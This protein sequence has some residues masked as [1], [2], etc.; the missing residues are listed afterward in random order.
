MAKRPQK[1]VMERHVTQEVDSVFSYL[2]TLRD[3]GIV[4]RSLW[5]RGIGNASHALIPSLF[6]HKTSVTKA[7]YS[8]L[9]QELNATFKMR[10]FP[11]TE[12]YKWQG[13]SWAQLFFMQHYRVPTRLLDWSGSP[14]IAL[15]FALTSTRLNSLGAPETDAAVWVLD[16][17]AWNVAVYEGTRFDGKVLTPGD[18][19]ARLSRYSPEDVYQSPSNFPPVAMR[20]IHNSAR[21]VAQQGFFTI[22]GPEKKSLED[23][24]PVKRAKPK[25]TDSLKTAFLK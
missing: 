8:R 23:F 10:G 25:N 12:S 3:N 21:I 7:D 4:D 16:P 5:Y 20:G 2:N 11:Y 9:E 18:E 24:F 19:D 6:R 22:Y 17:I 14:L 15:H 13:D 1:K